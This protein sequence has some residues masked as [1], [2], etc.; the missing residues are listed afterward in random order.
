MEEI[1]YYYGLYKKNKGDVK[2]EGKKEEAS[3]P[4]EEESKADNSAALKILAQL[5]T[6][7]NARGPEMNSHFSR[8]EQEV[9]NYVLSDK[10][11]QLA[12]PRV[13]QITKN[14]TLLVQGSDEE[15][16]NGFTYKQLL[17]KL[18]TK[19]ADEAFAKT[20]LSKLA[21][22]ANEA[23]EEKKEKKEEPAKEEAAKE[24]AAPAEEK[25]EEQERKPKREKKQR[26][27]KKQEQEE[28]KAEAEQDVIVPEG[29]KQA[30]EPVQE[31]TRAP[32]AEEDKQP[33]GRGGRGGRGKRSS[34]ER[35]PRQKKE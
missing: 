21:K 5:V 27:P 8:K 17:E 19:F 10:R 18:Q 22:K 24:E 13:D 35:K 6:I 23:S 4:K 9:L 20:N 2:E 25:Q 26:G 28:P 34:K 16:K 29:L 14:F 30:A 1:G 33:R 12:G 7:S 32:V 11:Y 3:Q 31:E 15:F